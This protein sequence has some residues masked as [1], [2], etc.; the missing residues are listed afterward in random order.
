M[1]GLGE[2]DS[3]DDDF[4]RTLGKVV[5]TM[6]GGG[7]AKDVSTL[8]FNKCT[9]KQNT[10]NKYVDFSAWPPCQA[11]LTLH[12]LRANRVAY[13]MKRFSVEQVEEPPLPDCGWDHEG[14]IIWI[15]EAY[16]S[17]V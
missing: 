8:Q 17:A 10:E 7:R 4:C 9:K 14:R 15:K 2:N 5:C 13:L 11:T 1:T 16:P 6:Y 3:V 12:I